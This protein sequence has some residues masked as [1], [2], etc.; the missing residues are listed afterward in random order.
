MTRE[1]V[2]S[3]IV[4]MEEQINS[5]SRCREI[6]TCSLK[7][8]VGRGDLEGKILVV[9]QNETD[10]TRDR[11]LVAKMRQDVSSMAGQDNGVYHTYL[12]RCHSK[13]C[14]RRNE[15]K[16]LFDGSL[17]NSDSVCLLTGD[18]CDAKNI[19][20]SDQHY[21]N[22][23]RFLLEEIE[24][25][26]PNMIITIGES[27]YQYVFR[28]FGLLDPFQRSFDENKN[29]LYK[30]NGCWFIPADPPT[31]GENP[32]LGHLKDLIKTAIN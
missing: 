23:L 5:C 3:R 11:N 7:P 30:S 17:I 6:R 19:E 1:S 13:L 27:T 12:V 26:S 2:I 25:L 29:K 22:C 21:M 18:F 4:K 8:S 32:Y 9:F 20:P 28:A 24:I 14:T 10:F 16:V 31:P 15:K